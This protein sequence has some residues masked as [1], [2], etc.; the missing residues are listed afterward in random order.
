V[1]PDIEERNEASKEF[2]EV[3][4]MPRMLRLSKVPV[5]QWAAAL[6]LPMAVQRNAPEPWGRFRRL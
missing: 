1:D 6:N 3:L 4:E 2:K 5:P